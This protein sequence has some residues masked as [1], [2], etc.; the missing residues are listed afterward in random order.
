MA[1]MMADANPGGCLRQ[2]DRHGNDHGGT[3]RFSGVQIIRLIFSESQEIVDDLWVT[4]F[5]MGRHQA[6]ALLSQR[7][8][9]L[10][11]AAY[12]L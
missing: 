12:D 6:H 2:P 7:F 1:A 10:E 4:A 11:R 3:N 5:A 8:P 9:M